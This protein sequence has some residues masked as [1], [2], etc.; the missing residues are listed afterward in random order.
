MKLVLATDLSKQGD[1]L[2]QF[3]EAAPLPSTVAVAATDAAAASAPPG[4]RIDLATPLL[5]LLT[6]GG[7]T[8]DGEEESDERTIFDFLA[9]EKKQRRNHLPGSGRRSTT[10]PPSSPNHNSSASSSSSYSGRNR[11]LLLRM[12]IKA[13]DVSNPA[14]RLDCYL[15]WTERII[16]EFHSQVRKQAI[17]T[18]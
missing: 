13:S 1:I 10:L 18:I 8:T 6:G 5:R 11:L 16:E 14:K 2:K 3:K 17:P 15:S 9:E 4:W 7:N 12:V